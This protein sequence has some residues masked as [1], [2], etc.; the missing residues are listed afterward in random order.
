MTQTNRIPRTGTLKLGRP[1]APDTAHDT[2]PAHVHNIGAFIART[3]P[4]TIAHIENVRTTL[5]VAKRGVLLS[6]SA[7]QA[8]T[9]RNPLLFH[10]R[11]ELIRGA[12]SDAEN[13][14]LDIVPVPDSYNDEDWKTRVRKAVRDTAMAHGFGPCADTCLVGHSKDQS[15]YYLSM[16]PDW[17]SVEVGNIGGISATPIRDAY[18]ADPIAGLAENAHLMPHNVV[19]F[20][21]QFALTPDYAWLVEECEW[22]RRNR[23][24][25]ES[26]EIPASI[27]D[28]LS[29]TDYAA[30]KARFGGLVHPPAI[31]ETNAVVV[32][33]GHVL[34][35]ERLKRPGLGLVALPGDILRRETFLDG[36]LRVL[37][38]DLRLLVADTRKPD[39]AKN[40]LEGKLQAEEVFDHPHRSDRGHLLSRTH[41]FVLK[42]SRNGLP[43]LGTGTSFQRP[44]WCPI[45]AIDLESMYE[46]SAHVVD[47]MLSLTRKRG[48]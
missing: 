31:V 7:F 36:I 30:I 8:R 14:R 44:F 5:R 27:R 33:S 48:I 1:P 39:A 40:L 16:F 20:L 15:S 10:E 43:P 41:L 9:P 21:R 18:F 13:A 23:A 45:E 2:L 11:A 35:V 38:D 24:R 6:G 28:K 26:V 25:F 3:E 32:Q 17:S 19:V 42:D 22:Y 29:N 37:V 4:P 46:D 34:L 47:R 12:L